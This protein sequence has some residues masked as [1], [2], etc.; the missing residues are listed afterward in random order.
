VKNARKKL[1]VG[2][3]ALVF[4]LG[5]SFTSSVEAKVP[6][7]MDFSIAIVSP[8]SWYGDIY[9]E[10]GSHG[11]LTLLV[12]TWEL[13]SQGQIVEGVWSI[14]WDD[15]N[16]LHG[17]AKASFVYS[18]HGYP[19]DGGYFVANGKVTAASAAW[20]DWNRRPIHM[21]A[22]VSPVPWVAEGVFQMN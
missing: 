3:L 8:V 22:D 19:A 16:Y 1:V 21:S 7:R 2:L 10:D 18:T 13:H 17:E 15:D 14:Y 9:A 11:I 6:M 12:T 4:L 5:F 20:A